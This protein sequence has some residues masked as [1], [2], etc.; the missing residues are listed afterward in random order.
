M[1]RPV[2]NMGTKL[3]VVMLSYEHHRRTPKARSVREAITSR[4]RE[5][6]QELLEE[7]GQNVEHTYKAEQVYKTLHVKLKKKRKKEKCH[8][9]FLRHSRHCGLY[10]HRSTNPIKLLGRLAEAMG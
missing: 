2:N 8:N 4:R 10:A 9:P 7:K 5:E 6:K 3:H 1:S